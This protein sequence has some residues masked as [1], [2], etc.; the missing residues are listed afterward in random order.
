[1]SSKIKVENREDLVRDAHSG[2]ILSTNLAAVHAYKARKNEI[3]KM[4]VLETKVVG[5]ENDIKD[6]K[7]LLQKLVEGKINQ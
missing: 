5:M 3:N 1:M 4:R 6:I 2:A 7:T